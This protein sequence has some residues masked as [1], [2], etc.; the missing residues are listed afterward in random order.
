MARSHH[1]KKHK[2]H[3]RQFKTSNDTGKIPSSAKIK[4]TGIF[5]LLGAATGFAISYFATG[6]S[7]IWAS[8]SVIAGGIAGYYIGKTIDSDK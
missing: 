4:T 1:R 8:V 3:L 7:I 6:F 2:E 5:T